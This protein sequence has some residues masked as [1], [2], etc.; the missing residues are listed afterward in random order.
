MNYNFPHDYRSAQKTRRNVFPRQQ[1]YPIVPVGSPQYH[2]FIDYINHLAPRTGKPG[3][4]SKYH[5][6]P[7]ILQELPE[8]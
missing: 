1:I 7:D 3:E 4:R 2:R 8:N 6:H 5:T